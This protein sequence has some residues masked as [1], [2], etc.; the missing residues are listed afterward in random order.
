MITIISITTLLCIGFIVYIIKTPASTVE[1]TPVINGKLHHD[2][3]I[4]SKSILKV[5]WE[6]GWLNFIR[7]VLAIIGLITVIGWFV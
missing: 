5:S 3:F 1:V 7:N 2:T 6:K 4:S